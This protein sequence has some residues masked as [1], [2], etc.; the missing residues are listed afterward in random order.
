M[1]YPFFIFNLPAQVPSGLVGI[2]MI[3]MILSTPSRLYR[4][5][6]SQNASHLRNRTQQ[7]NRWPQSSYILAIFSTLYPSLQLL[8]MHHDGVWYC[9]WYWIIHET[10]L[11]NYSVSDIW[12]YLWTSC[13]HGR[14]CKLKGL[15]PL[16]C[17][18]NSFYKDVLPVN[19][20]TLGWAVKE[21]DNLLSKSSMPSVS[22]SPSSKT[23][24]ASK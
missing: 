19:G 18:L 1:P 15:L 4:F 17:T 8:V 7:Q 11:G 22:R 12:W 14:F 16:P 23:L 6:L 9:Y 2:Q 10:I 20:S 3:L 21:C 13:L 24:T 5:P